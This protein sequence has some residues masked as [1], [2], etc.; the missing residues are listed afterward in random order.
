MA[1][2]RSTFV[3]EAPGVIAAGVRDRFN[4]AFSGSVTNISAVVGTAPVGGN[5]VF[6]V[7]KEGVV[8]ATCTI[9]AGTTEVNVDL[10]ANINNPVA[11]L[12]N[13][14]PQPNPITGPTESALIRFG[15]GTTFDLSVTSV[16]TTTA[17]SDLN[18]TVAFS[19]S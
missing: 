2:N 13:P 12:A 16:G 15:E 10:I 4:A 3:L 11:T 9:A 7:R 19:D 18:V 6:D 1:D 17:G 14:N 5:L 8:L